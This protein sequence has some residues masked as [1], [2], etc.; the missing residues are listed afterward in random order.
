MEDLKTD[1]PIE[2]SVF[3]HSPGDGRKPAPTTKVLKEGKE[4]TKL[5]LTVDASLSRE[6]RQ[7]TLWT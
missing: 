1:A 2:L 5:A 7:R 6:V 3:G 4:K